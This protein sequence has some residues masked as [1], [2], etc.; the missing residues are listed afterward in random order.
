MKNSQAVEVVKNLLKELDAK[1]DA[2]LKTLEM[3][4]ADSTDGFVPAISSQNKPTSSPYSV[5]G[6]V[7]NA[8]IELIHKLG[9]QVS[10]S[11]ILNQLN[12]KSISLGEAKDKGAALASI[13]Y[14]EVS[15][16]SGRL[17]RVARG[18]YDL[19]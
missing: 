9:R 19:R 8:T 13:L 6:R 1:R 14:Q 17:K 4:E 18:I 16:K 11:E 10:N 12:E 15:K 7:V 2:L 3:L 5:Q